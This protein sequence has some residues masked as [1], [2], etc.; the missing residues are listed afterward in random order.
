MGR[1]ALTSGAICGGFRHHPPCPEARLSLPGA[2]KQC[3]ASKRDPFNAF[4]AYVRIE[5]LSANLAG[6]SRQS[7]PVNRTQCQIPVHQGEQDLKRMMRIFTTLDKTP[8]MLNP[9]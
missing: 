3:G 4:R 2:R 6:R 8:E 9:K 1:G 5:T 7:V